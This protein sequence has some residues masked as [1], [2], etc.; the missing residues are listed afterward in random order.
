METRGKKIIY[1][2]LLI[3]VAM[4]TGQV[5]LGGITRL[6]G[7][8]L[9]ITEWEVFTVVPPLNPEQW[10][11]AFDLYKATPQYEKVNKGMSLSEFKLIYFWE[12]FHRNWARLIGFV[13]LIPFLIFLTKGWLTKKLV[14]QLGLIIF[15]TLVTATFGWFMVA[16][17]LVDRPWVNAYMLS[18][19]LI[20][21]M[22]LAALLYYV[23]LDYRFK[24]QSISSIYSPHKKFANW[25]IAAIVLQ[26]IFGGWMSGMKAGLFYPTWPD[27]NGSIIPSVLFDV[28]NW[29]AANIREYDKHLFAPALVQVLHRFWAYLL[30]VMVII[31][32]VRTR[33]FGWPNFL[34]KS[35]NYLTGI[36]LLQVV[37]GIITLI[38]CKGHIPVAIAALHQL[39]ALVLLLA[40]VR[41]R[42]QIR[43]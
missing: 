28:S 4:L 33:K 17:G 35:N 2:W 21:G 18:L 39:T 7:S 32:W 41:V 14:I 20:L 27:M 34:K 23:S 11:E 5:I 3:G 42:F 38:S 8:G 13:F 10:N 29:T 40:A 36:L 37:L 15:W 26:I 31:F 22:G 30:A 6:T 1:V 12:F 9:S 25:I 16:S 43:T 19:H 24:P